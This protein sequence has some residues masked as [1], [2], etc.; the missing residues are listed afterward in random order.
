MQKPDPVTAL[1]FLTE[2]LT[3][4]SGDGAGVDEWYNLKMGEG[5][6]RRGRRENCGLY[7]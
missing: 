4:S 2:S 1:L 5:S 7:M 6:G 3:P